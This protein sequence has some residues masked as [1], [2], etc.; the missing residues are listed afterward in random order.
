[1]VKG[2]SLL[3]PQDIAEK[4]NNPVVFVWGKESE[5]QRKK[6]KTGIRRTAKGG[7]NKKES[8]Q[9]DGPTKYHKISILIPLVFM[10]R[11]VHKSENVVVKF[12]RGKS[13]LSILLLQKRKYNCDFGVV[14]N[15]SVE[16]KIHRTPPR[17]N[18]PEPSS[19][20]TGTHSRK[21]KEWSKLSSRNPCQRKPRAHSV[22]GLLPKRG[23][24]GRNLVRGK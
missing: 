1:M 13:A 17:E 20:A 21:R 3:Q 23:I 16:G 14:G 22:A 8:E 15:R 11:A 19:M 7:K 9:D 12:I 24:P 10:L 2:D 6:R 5:Q 4:R 18:C